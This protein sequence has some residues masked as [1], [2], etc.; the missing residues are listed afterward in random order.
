MTPR[1]SLLLVL[2]AVVACRDDHV[3]PTER[4]VPRE[5]CTIDVDGTLICVRD[6]GPGGG[7]DARDGGGGDARDGGGDARDGGGCD[8]GD[9][10]CD[11]G[12]G[13]GRRERRRR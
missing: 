13:G 5:A 2:C 12:D 4:A 1:W 6:G 3:E 8:A 11:A 10:G 9:G 7:G